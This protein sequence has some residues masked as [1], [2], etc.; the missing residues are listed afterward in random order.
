L[1]YYIPIRINRN[2]KY[3][4]KIKL[5]D[6]LEKNEDA[7]RTLSCIS[8]NFICIVI[9]VDIEREKL[10]LIISRLNNFIPAEIRIDYNTFQEYISKEDESVEV[11]GIDIFNS[12]QNFVQIMSTS[13]DKQVIVNTVNEIYQIAL[14]NNE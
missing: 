13:T 7:K 6:L 2:I 12:I 11:V 1:I 4:I 3:H 8:G 10:D 14:N 5:S 9:D